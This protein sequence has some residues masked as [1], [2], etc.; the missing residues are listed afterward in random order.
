MF[1]NFH[2]IILVWIDYKIGSDF[3]LIVTKFVFLY[4]SLL[5]SNL[6]VENINKPFGTGFMAAP[7]S[8][9]DSRPALWAAF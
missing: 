7:P 6:S 1:I 4:N 2:N 3:P 9:S 5:P 8:V